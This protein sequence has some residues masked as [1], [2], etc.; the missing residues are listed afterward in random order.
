[1]SLE[2]MGLAS[3]EGRK[4]PW[5]YRG[6]DELGLTL[7]QCILQ[8]NCVE[9]YEKIQRAYQFAEWFAAETMKTMWVWI[10]VFSEM[11]TSGKLEKYN[12]DSSA[13]GATKGMSESEIRTWHGC[14]Y[15]VAHEALDEFVTEFWKQRLKYFSEVATEPPKPVET[16]PASAPS[17]SSIANPKPASAE[18]PRGLPAKE[19]NPEALRAVARRAVVM[20]ILASKRWKRG[21]WATKAGV[22]KNSV[23]EYLNGTRT[24]TDQNRKAMA[25]ALELESEDLPN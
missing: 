2:S 5:N 6:R 14:L 22:G 18:C 9:P 3:R 7:A 10:S 25:E 13:D 23:Y 1:M 11:N 21:R 17:Q 15:G 8:P 12:R 20:P 4:N 16:L 24:L 19:E